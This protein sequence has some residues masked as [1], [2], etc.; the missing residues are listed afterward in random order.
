MPSGMSAIEIDLL[1]ERYL[2]T[3]EAGYLLGFSYAEHQSSWRGT[4]V[5]RRGA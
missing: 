3:P 4:D 1:I 5:D 2:H